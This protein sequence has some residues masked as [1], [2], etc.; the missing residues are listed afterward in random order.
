[1][2][3]Y[4]SLRPVR[5]TSGAPVGRSIRVGN[6]PRMPSAHRLVSG[7]RWRT[8]TVSRTPS[9]SSCTAHQ[10]AKRGTSRRPVSSRVA[11]R[12]R[13]RD[14][15]IDASA[16]SDTRWA[17]ASVAWRARARTTAPVRASAT[18][19]RSRSSS[20]VNR[21]GGKRQ[22]Q[23]A[24][25]DVAAGQCQRVQAAVGG[26][27]AGQLGKGGLDLAHRPIVPVY[28]LAHG[29]GARHVAGQRDLLEAVGRRPTPALPGHAAQDVVGVERQH[30]GRGRAEGGHR[31][32]DEA[33]GDVLDR[34]CPGQLD[35]ER[36]E[37]TLGQL[38]V[39]LQGRAATLVDL[40]GGHDVPR[41]RGAQQTTRRSVH[42]LLPPR[43]PFQ[44][45]DPTE[46]VDL[47]GHATSSGPPRGSV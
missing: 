14:S 35:G 16:S 2:K 34:A 15:V 3:G 13:L 19:R 1:M 23:R 5:T 46:A 7:S 32:G 8:P 4:I 26:V 37:H 36:V 28:A 40:L 45:P 22:G 31:M 42:S 10:S 17:A 29:D 18:A 27:V 12:S 38:G 43:L 20:G 41:H 44:T 6:T 39:T 33:V 11:W 9:R 30:H 47:R 25:G 24:V 21:P